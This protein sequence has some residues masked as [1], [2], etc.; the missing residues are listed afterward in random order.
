MSKVTTATPSST[1]DLGDV[2]DAHAGDA[3]RLA[4]ARDDRLGGLELGLELEGLLL[5]HRD[6]QALLLE[7][8]VGDAER[9]DD[10]A[11]DG[12]EVAQVLADRVSSAL[13]SRRPRRRPR[14]A[15]SRA[16]A[17]RRSLGLAALG[18]ESSR[19]SA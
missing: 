6:P 4:L 10:Q 5:E 16:S 7:D 19:P 3:D 2:A 17:W 14:P 15:R 9:D 12:D 8:V 11:G 1:L 18:V 13:L